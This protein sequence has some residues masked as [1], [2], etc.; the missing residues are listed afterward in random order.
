MLRTDA[1]RD[2]PHRTRSLRFVGDWCGCCILMCDSLVKGNKLRGCHAQSVTRRPQD[3]RAHNRP[4][5]LSLQNNSDAPL[6][7]ARMP[8]SSLLSVFNVLRIA[9]KKQ[10]SVLGGK[11]ILHFPAAIYCNIGI[12]EVCRLRYHPSATRCP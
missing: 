12:H 3:A 7:H 10:K 2:T 8:F 4:C 11:Y 9:S 5:D 1:H 6:D